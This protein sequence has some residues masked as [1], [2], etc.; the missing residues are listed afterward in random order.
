MKTIVSNAGNTAEVAQLRKDI[1][2]L[3]E[4]NSKVEVHLVQPGIMYEVNDVYHTVIDFMNEWVGYN[5]K[6]VSNLVPIKKVCVDFE[7]SND[8]FLAGHKL[9]QQNNKCKDLLAKCVPHHKKNFQLHWDFLLGES[10]PNK[11][12]LYNV[13][14]KHPIHGK[15]F[16]TYY[17][18]D[19]NK[20][21]WSDEV[22]RPKAHTAETIGDR[23]NTQIRCSD[24]IDPSI[25]NQTIYSA[26]IETTIHN[27]FAMF[28]EKE[29]KPIVAKR[30]FVIFGTAGQLKAFKQLGY[31]TFDLVIDESYDDIEDK[32][33]RWHKALDS[34]SKLSL[35]Y[36]LRVYARLKP[37]LEHNKKHFESF[38]WRKSFRHSQ[39]YV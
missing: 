6:F 23:Y 3:F 32:E 4:T 26:M 31:K 29:A 24:L 19:S 11:D 5:I 9:Y 8:M 34:M 30:P 7:Y 25:Y 1:L 16:L 33:T 37:I 38:E 2:K 10:S 35:K 14:S 13:I 39:D 27:D 28:S 21:Y 36:P 17:G 18:K 15:T 20:G 12:W 22:V